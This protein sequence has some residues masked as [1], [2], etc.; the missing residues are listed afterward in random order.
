[1]VYVCN[2]GNLTVNSSRYPNGRTPI[3]C[4]TG[5]TPVCPILDLTIEWKECRA[6]CYGPMLLLLENEDLVFTIGWKE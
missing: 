6:R 5:D 2:T 3:E 1:M 4:I